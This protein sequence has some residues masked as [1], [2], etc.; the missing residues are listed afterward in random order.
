MKREYEG[1]EV[2]LK[3]ETKDTVIFVVGNPRS[4]TTMMGRILGKNDVVYTVRRESHFFENLYAPEDRNRKL[5]GSEASDLAARLVCIENDGFFMQ[6]DPTRFE[7][8]ARAI[9]QSVNGDISHAGTIY[10]AFLRVTAKENGK[11][12]PCDHTPGYVYYIPEVL[13][14][15]PTAR[16][17]NMVRD[18]RDVLLSQ[19]NRWKRR[20]LGEQ[21][22]PLRLTFRTW[23]N[24]HPVATSILWRAAVRRAY[25]NRNDARVCSLRFEDVLTD[26]EKEV[27]KLCEFIDIPY[28]DK[29]LAVPMVGS[30]LIPDNT[31]RKGVDKTRASN[32]RGGGL[33]SAEIFINQTIT[34]KY[35]REL[36][37]KQ[38]RVFPNPLALIYY[39]VTFPIK[40]SLTFLIHMNRIKNVR[41][42]VKR[43]L[44]FSGISHE[45]TSP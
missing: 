25:A 26:P 3:K 32:W 4:G 14:L 35:M 34:A 19:K 2:Q 43:R 23:M 27:R 41:E 9:I 11:A 28:D 12:V 5:S 45:A 18:P 37:Y 6:G 17:I 29:M 42:A 8:K 22:K 16:I 21:G 24:Y 44:P 39:L 10:D 15:F 20:F 7:E 40:I 33:N 30:S 1:T 38:V 31:S 13:S 36:G